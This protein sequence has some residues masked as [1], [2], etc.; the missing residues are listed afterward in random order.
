MNVLARSLGASLHIIDTGVAFAPGEM[1]EPQPDFFERSVHPEGTRNLLQDNAMTSEECAQAMYTGREQARLA[2]DDGVHA[3][4]LGDIGVASSTSAAIL[5]AALLPAT[6]GALTGRGTGADTLRMARKRQVIQSALAFHGARIP[7]W[8]PLPWLAAVGGYEIAAITGCILE[9]ARLDLPVLI[10]GFTAS[11]AAL[12]AHRL[13]PEALR[14]CFF[15]HRSPGKGHRLLL[16]TLEAKP[17]LKL[18]IRLGEATGAA[19]AFPLLQAAAHLLS[20]MATRAPA[21]LNRS[22][23]RVRY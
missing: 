14:C 15:A 23:P 1:P 19:L 4:A 5:C 18:G 13:K 11:T 8:E 20:H 22:R 21:G 2:Q 12:V 9:A 16:K 10:D 7:D 3:L 6:P 17:L